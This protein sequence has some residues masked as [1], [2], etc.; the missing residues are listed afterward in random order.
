M[1]WVFI[2]I[3]VASLT[4]AFLPGN[5]GYT[6]SEKDKAKRARRAR[7]LNHLEG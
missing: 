6:R 3:V 7:W 1:A 5:A 4:F 2:I